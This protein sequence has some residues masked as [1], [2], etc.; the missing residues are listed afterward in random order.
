VL[1][2]SPEHVLHLQRLHV[3]GPGLLSIMCRHLDR[4]GKAQNMTW[5]SV[6]AD[7]TADAETRSVDI[8]IDVNALDRLAPGHWMIVDEN[9][10][11]ERHLVL[12]R[13]LV[14]SGSDEGST[15][16][17]IHDLIRVGHETPQLLI[18]PT[19]LS[20]LVPVVV[21][22]GRIDEAD[23]YWLRLFP[24]QASLTA[25]QASL[26]LCLACVPNSSVPRGL[27]VRHSNVVVISFQLLDIEEILLDIDSL[28][29]AAADDAIALPTS[30]LAPLIASCFSSS[31]TWNIRV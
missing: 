3:M 20:Q 14:S 12:R 21:A 13:S 4:A 23:M 29:A 28:H 27:S 15:K 1:P 7:A 19:K 30:A 9:E 31:R 2:A 5:I 6:H 24:H 17:W 25:T 16:T 11:G 22:L 18:G 26:L 10:Q 8:R